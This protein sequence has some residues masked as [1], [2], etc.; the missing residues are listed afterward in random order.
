MN[1]AV[2][3]ALNLDVQD[4]TSAEAMEPLLDWYSS[5]D[6]LCSINGNMYIEEVQASVADVLRSAG[7][8]GAAHPP[9]MEDTQLSVEA[10]EAAPDGQMSVEEEAALSE[11][12]PQSHPRSPLR[13]CPR[14]SSLFERISAHGSALDRL[15]P[16]DL[17]KI[18]IL[19]HSGPPTDSSHSRPSHLFPPQPNGSTPGVPAHPRLG[20][21]P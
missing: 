6:K 16:H 1:R 13:H 21:G 15:S 2:D 5:A 3:V 19:H 4:D 12:M 7:L 17:D 9:P 11:S 14:Q 10:G 20:R 8:S 18:Q